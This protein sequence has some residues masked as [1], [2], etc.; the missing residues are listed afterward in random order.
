MNIDT[1]DRWGV[2]LSVTSDSQFLEQC[3]AKSVFL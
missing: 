3:S 2:I 1:T